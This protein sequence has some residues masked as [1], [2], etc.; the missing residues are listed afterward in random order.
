MGPVP[1][2]HLEGFVHESHSSSRHALQEEWDF[3][4]VSLAVHSDAS[5]GSV[6]LPDK[7]NLS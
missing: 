7:P 3:S 4:F 1:N 5:D 6:V 2:S